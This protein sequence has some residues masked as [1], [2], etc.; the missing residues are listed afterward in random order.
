MYFIDLRDKSAY[1]AHL[2]H[3]FSFEVLPPNGPPT[4]CRGLLCVRPFFLSG[5]W[6]NL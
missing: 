2:K 4:Q 1:G 5:D 3:P 6:F